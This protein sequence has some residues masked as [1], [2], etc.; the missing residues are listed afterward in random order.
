M[1]ATWHQQLPEEGSFSLAT[2]MC[3]REEEEDE[4]GR[5]EPPQICTEPVL[6]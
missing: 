6:G 2:F 1:R 3:G 5:T 4:V